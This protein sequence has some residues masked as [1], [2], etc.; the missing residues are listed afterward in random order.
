MTP[1][2]W[3]VR[4]PANDANLR[5]QA[6]V[7]KLVEFSAEYVAVEAGVLIFRNRVGGSYPITVRC[8]APGY[9]LEVI[10]VAT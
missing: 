4:V 9:W 3:Q 6:G 5:A 8:F 1:P 10:R 7:T 2:M